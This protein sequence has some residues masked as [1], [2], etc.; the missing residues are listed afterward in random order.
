MRRLRRTPAVRADANA[1]LDG[2][3]ARK[4]QNRDRTAVVPPPAPGTTLAGDADGHRSG[5]RTGRL[6]EV[7]G[8]SVA[9]ATDADPVVAVV[10]AAPRHPYTQLLLSAVP[11]PTAGRE[12]T[13]RFDA[14]EPPK[15]VDPAPGCRFEPRCPLAIDVCRHVAPQL[16]AVA[17]SQF[18]ACRVALM[19][20][21]VG[22]ALPVG[23]PS[24][25][26]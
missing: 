9:Y 4:S 3:D 15:V 8:L 19:Q 14:A 7:R 11:D 16:G 24:V 1:A 17:P 21:R 22:G 6:L 20:A 18:A 25:A 5:P 10:M 23:R 13:G 26:A 12:K 2:G